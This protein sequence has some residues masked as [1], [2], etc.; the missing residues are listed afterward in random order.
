[1]HRL[2][3]PHNVLL[4]LDDRYIEFFHKTPI[5]QQLFGRQPLG[6]LLGEALRIFL[7]VITQ[8]FQPQFGVSHAALG[9]PQCFSGILFET[10]GMLH[11]GAEPFRSH[12]V[13]TETEGA[14]LIGRQQPMQ[15]LD[16][17]RIVHRFAVSL[18]Q[19]RH[20][21]A[22]QRDCVIEQRVGTGR[23]G[24]NTDQIAMLFVR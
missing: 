4:L 7:A 17:L 2:L 9:L 13:V 24:A 15:T 16:A 19:K 10:L 1:M 23:V 20:H 21:G 12:D 3:S 8:L 11:D 6:P 5:V 18:A 14:R 22:M